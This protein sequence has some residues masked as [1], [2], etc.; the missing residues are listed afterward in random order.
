MKNFII[1][2]LTAYIFYGLCEV[3]SVLACGILAGVVWFILED[4]DEQI[5]ERR[6]IVRRGR[7]LKRKIRGLY[8]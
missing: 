1:A 7:R 6:E 2:I 8:E 4:I 5:R 3:K